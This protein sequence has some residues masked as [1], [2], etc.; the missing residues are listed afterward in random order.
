MKC[1]SLV[2]LC[3]FDFCCIVFWNNLDSFLLGY[4]KI[5]GLLVEDIVCVWYIFF[6]EVFKGFKEK[7][8]LVV[9]IDR[10]GDCCK[11]CV[12]FCMELRWLMRIV[13][14]FGILK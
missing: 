10:F 14:L 12:E 5:D 2:L 7:I 11:I 1:L 13:L 4:L 3:S 6:F 9:F 8:K